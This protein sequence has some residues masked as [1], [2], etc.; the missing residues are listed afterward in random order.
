MA[1]VSGRAEAMEQTN[2]SID[3]NA[4]FPARVIMST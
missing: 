1:V 2:D 4:V 3:V